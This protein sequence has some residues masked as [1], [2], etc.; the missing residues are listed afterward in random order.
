MKKL[1][2]LEKAFEG[3]IVVKCI[4]TNGLYKKGQW[5]PKKWNVIVHHW[6]GA[7]LFKSISGAKNALNCWSPYKTIREEWFKKYYQIYKFTNGNLIS[8]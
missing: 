7:R 4:H 1:S 6:S 8:V 3:F 5:V 2:E